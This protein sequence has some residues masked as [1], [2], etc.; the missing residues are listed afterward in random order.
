[1]QHLGDNPVSRIL[2]LWACCRP[3]GFHHLSGTVIT[4]GL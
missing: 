1:M 3:S 4:N 2:F